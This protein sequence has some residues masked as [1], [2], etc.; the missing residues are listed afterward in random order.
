LATLDSLTGGT[1]RRL[2]PVT[3]AE[4]R[5]RRPG[6]HV[7]CPCRSVAVSTISRHWSGS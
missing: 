5:D 6:D 1:T 7:A 3:P 2:V 4:R